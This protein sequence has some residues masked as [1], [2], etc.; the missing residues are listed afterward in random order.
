MDQCSKHD[1]PL[2]FSAILINQ[3]GHDLCLELEAQ[4][5]SVLTGQ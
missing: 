2:A 5:H 3:P 1:T 4:E